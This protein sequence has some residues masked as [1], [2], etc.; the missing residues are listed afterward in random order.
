MDIII[1]LIVGVCG[2][3]TE[4]KGTHDL[5]IYRYKLLNNDIAMD[6][7]RLGMAINLILSTPANYN[8]FRLSIMETVWGTNEVDNKK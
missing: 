8:A 1:Y 4:P 3:L 7:A 2:Y 5:I 6:L